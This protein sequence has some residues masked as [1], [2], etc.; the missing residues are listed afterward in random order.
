[1]ATRLR[2]KG[3]I[4]AQAMA[5]AAWHKLLSSQ[6]RKKKKG[7]HHKPASLSTGWIGPDVPYSDDCPFDLPAEEVALDQ[8]FHQ[9]VSGL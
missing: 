1:M 6:P 9:L 2:W 7:R 8:E 3:N 4:Q 5:D